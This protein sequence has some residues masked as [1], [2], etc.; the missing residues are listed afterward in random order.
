[1]WGRGGGVDCILMSCS[2]YITYSFVRI[3]FLRLLVCRLYL[4]PT[5]VSREGFWSSPVCASIALSMAGIMTGPFY[6]HK[7]TFSL[8]ITEV[9][10]IKIALVLLVHL[11]Y[12]QRL[13]QSLIFCTYGISFSVDSKH[14][15][16]Y[17]ETRRFAALRYYRASPY[18][19]IYTMKKYTKSN[20][21]VRKQRVSITKFFP[22]SGKTW[23]RINFFFA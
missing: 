6:I 2:G 23:S 12:V 15:A 9:H 13:L 21:E 8:N 1:M 20:A 22:F 18:D 17:L 11:I 5:C 10:W 4:I 14:R 7:Y 16:I 3:I 19:G